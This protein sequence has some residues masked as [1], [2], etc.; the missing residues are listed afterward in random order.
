MV[1]ALG[2][3]Q[4]GFHRPAVRAGLRAWMPAVDDVQSRTGACGLVGQLA[5]ELRECGVLDR[6]GEPVV[7]DHARHVQVLDADVRVGMG[8]HGGGLVQEVASQVGHTC[9]Q[10]RHVR[11]RL[12]AAVGAPAFAAQAPL[13][14]P[15]TREIRLQGVR[16]AYHGAVRQCGEFLHAQ[17]DSDAPA[18]RGLGC[19]IVGSFDGQAGLPASRT[20]GH[21]HA[22]HLRAVHSLGRVLHAVHTA[23]PREFQRV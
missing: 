17:V 22:Q 3:G 20:A 11:P 12:A 5:S 8:E 19:G 6:L 15:Q 16:V 21:A 4:F 7:F 18:L 13:G 23:Y 9:V 1:D 14:F 10:A 2:Q